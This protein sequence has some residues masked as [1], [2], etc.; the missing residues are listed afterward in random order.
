MKKVCAAL[1]IALC[2]WCSGVFAQEGDHFAEGTITVIEN[3]IITVS[4]ADTPGQSI[5]LV[6]QDF[7]AYETNDR[8]IRFSDLSVGMSVR[9]AYYVYP[10]M[11]NVLTHLMVLEE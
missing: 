6:T 1:I 8:G 3:G 4:V 2:V 5:D 7:T 11:G 9:A 10:N